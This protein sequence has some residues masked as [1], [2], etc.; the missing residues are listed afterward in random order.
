[1]SQSSNKSSLPRLSGLPRP[2]RLPV[3]QN[4]FDPPAVPKIPVKYHVG[5]ALKPKAKSSEKDG[6]EHGSE[7]G[8]TQLEG[9]RVQNCA[10][11]P[12][13]DGCSASRRVEPIRLEESEIKDRDDSTATTDPNQPRRRPRP[14]LSDRTI[15]TLSQI[16]PSPSPRR[17]RSSFFPAESPERN[18]P[19]PGSPLS[20]QRPSTSHGQ[21]PG[22]PTMAPRLTS[23]VKRPPILPPPSNTK[24]SNTTPARRAVSSYTPN[25]LRKSGIKPRTGLDAT[26]SKP[27][28]P[29]GDP[30]LQ[31]VTEHMSRSSLRLAAGS[32]T[33]SPRS[34][35]P[36]AGI[37]GIFVKPD[38]PTG[39]PKNANPMSRRDISDHSTSSA[40][41]SLYS[42]TSR[43]SSQ[44]SQASTG[45][46]I[47]STTR[48]SP[49]SKSS[50]SAA[51]RDTIAQAKAAHRKAAQSG[52]K[53]P[54]K[55]GAVD[56]DIFPASN[57]KGLLRKRIQM[58]RTD[59]RLNIAA[60]GLTE[61]PSEVMSMYDLDTVD[62]S[63][64]A[65]YESVDITRLIAADNQFQSLSPDLFPDREA[66]DLG[67]ADE[68]SKVTL[69]GGLETLDLHGNILGA[70]PIGYVFSGPLSSICSPC[71]GI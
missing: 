58:A 67:N 61:F 49:G 38:I 48:V 50:S 14:S 39:L 33:Y 34:I 55:S 66:E 18:P 28:K 2:S 59:G 32:K 40:S 52:L 70:L 16:P 27:S 19:R 15:E 56:D 44:T 29:T 43:K 5:A 62:A 31:P 65:W 13:D 20:R 26:P 24:P 68:D 64:G 9:D 47:A 23:P 71:R 25:S 60:L 41:S 37:G 69:F 21:R 51:L 53:G 4:A 36:R 12:V 10:T 35:K 11:E 7:K 30:A 57:N 1:M 17:R 46:V 42:P 63:G 6:H 22:L 3:S 45:S 8:D 54:Q